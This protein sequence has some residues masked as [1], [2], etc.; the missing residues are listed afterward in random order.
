MSK[1]RR[2]LLAQALTAAS[3]FAATFG[4]SSAAAA[5]TCRGNA[6]EYVLPT[7]TQDP[8]LTAYDVNRDGVICIAV[9]G[10]RT[11]YSDNRTQAA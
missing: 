7:E 9:R 8:A 11:A 2:I 6:S 4:A 5:G 3:V 1:R 10:H